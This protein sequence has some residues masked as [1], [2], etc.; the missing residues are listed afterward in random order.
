ML[1][2]TGQGRVI[3][4]PIY[5]LFIND[6]MYEIENS[7]LGMCFY[8]ISC[9]CPTVA[10]DMVLIS[11]SKAALEKML[12]ICFEYALNGDT[13]IMPLRA[14]LWCLMKKCLIN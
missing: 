11:F 1:R 5:L 2:G 10:D 3:S 7:K 13:S 12:R 6:L 9:C 4:P 8:H 14:L